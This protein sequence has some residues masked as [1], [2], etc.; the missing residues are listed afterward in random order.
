MQVSNA[1]RVALPLD[2]ERRA[3][4]ARYAEP[5]WLHQAF[6][7]RGDG[8]VRGVFDLP[9][10]LADE[11]ELATS[12][13]LRSHFH[14][15]V[16]AAALGPHRELGTTRAFLEEALARVRANELCDTFEIETYTFPV[17]PDGP[18][19]DAALVAAIAAEYRWTRAR[20]D[21]AP[22]T[23]PA[24]ANPRDRRGE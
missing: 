19:G 10:L 7:R 20:L 3:A 14:V 11:R 24:R 8:S 4:L 9:E 6:V 21:A 18:A 13:E 22:A 1:L 15:P 12:R 23:P 17:L 16:D 5:R 2:A